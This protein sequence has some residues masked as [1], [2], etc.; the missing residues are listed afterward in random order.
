MTLRTIFQ[1]FPFTPNRSTSPRTAALR[2]GLAP[3]RTHT[4]SP[5]IALRFAGGPSAAKQVLRAQTAVLWAA[6]S[7]ED[8]GAGATSRSRL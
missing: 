7:A 3:P 5:E 4:N 2:R 8:E 1:G 6:A